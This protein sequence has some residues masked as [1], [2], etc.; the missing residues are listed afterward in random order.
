MKPFQYLF[1][2]FSSII[3]YLNSNHSGNNLFIFHLRDNCFEHIFLY[4][5]RTTTKSKKTTT[6]TITTSTTDD[7]K[8]KEL[9]FSI[10][11][12][13]HFIEKKEHFFLFIYFLVGNL[14]I[15][16]IVSFAIIIIIYSFFFTCEFYTCRHL[17]AA[18]WKAPT[19]F[20]FPNQDPSPRCYYCSLLSAIEFVVYF[21]HIA[22]CCAI[23]FV[24]ASHKT[25][26]VFKVFYFPPFFRA[27]WPN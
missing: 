10:N 19:K 2:M 14:W 18:Q 9:N 13:A 12:L 22:R 26:I 7:Y 4:L 5:F 6:T 11:F 8:K 24:I 25:I 1:D 16:S 17:C 27:N 20:C 21:I 15:T 3:V 23:V